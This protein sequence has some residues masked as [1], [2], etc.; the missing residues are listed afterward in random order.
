MCNQCEILN[1]NGINCHETG[2]PESW[3]EETLCKW[4]GSAFIPD[5]QWQL[6]CCHTCDTAYNNY[7]CNCEECREGI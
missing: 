5:N 7:P 4:C 1:I 6:C 3:R 2:C